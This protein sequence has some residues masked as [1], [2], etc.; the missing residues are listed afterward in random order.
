MISECI[1]DD[2]HFKYGYP[3]SN[4]LVTFLLKKDSET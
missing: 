3:H 4:A 2:I 1:S